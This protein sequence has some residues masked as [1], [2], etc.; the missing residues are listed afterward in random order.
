MA[1]LCWHLLQTIK[2][3]FDGYHKPFEIESF[4]LFRTNYK[5]NKEEK[6]PCSRTLLRLPVAYHAAMHKSHRLTFQKLPWNTV[7]CCCLK[8]HKFSHNATYAT[9]IIVLISEDVLV[10]DRFA[11]DKL[12]AVRWMA[13]LLIDYNWALREFTDD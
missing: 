3:H 9:F 12:Y 10:E 11:K 5:K 1:L 6:A 2:L 7:K 8:Q 4:Y 13:Y